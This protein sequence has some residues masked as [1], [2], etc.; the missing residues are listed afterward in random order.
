MGHV[1]QCP[2]AGDAYHRTYLVI[3]L[4]VLTDGKSVIALCW[5]AAY[6]TNDCVTSCLCTTVLYVQSLWWAEQPPC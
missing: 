6:S 3:S 5:I 2:I 1:P 4:I